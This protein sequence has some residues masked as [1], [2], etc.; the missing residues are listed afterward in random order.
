MHVA[1]FSTVTDTSVL[2]GCE[3]IPLLASNFIF[4]IFMNNSPLKQ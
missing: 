3:K 1:D 2:T 4:V